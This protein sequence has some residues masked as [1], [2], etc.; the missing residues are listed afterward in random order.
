MAKSANDAKITTTQ[1]M[2]IMR[3]SVAVVSLPQTI[4]HRTTG[5]ERYKTVQRREN[6]KSGERNIEMHPTNP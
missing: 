2:L 4:A 5:T 6:S 3:S 1:V